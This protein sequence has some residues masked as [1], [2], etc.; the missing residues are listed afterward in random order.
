MS[1][2]ERTDPGGG[3]R[4]WVHTLITFGP[5]LPLAVGVGMVIDTLFDPAVS[6]ASALTLTLIPAISTVVGISYFGH[7]HRPVTQ[8]RRLA[9]VGVIVVL[10]VVCVGW[11]LVGPEAPFARRAS[12]FV[13]IGGAVIAAIAIG[14]RLLAERRDGHLLSRGSDSGQQSAT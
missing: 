13:V 11:L 14:A 6:L 8:R 3:G 10:A 7:Q 5:V 4:P 2:S 12:L 1:E 9:G